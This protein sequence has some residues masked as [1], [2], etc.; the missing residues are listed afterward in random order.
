[1][2]L[3]IQ[4]GHNQQN[5]GNWTH[6]GWRK[7]FRF[8]SQLILRV[9]L[10]F[11]V[12]HRRAWG[13]SENRWQLGEAR[14]ERGEGVATQEVIVNYAACSSRLQMKGRKK[15]KYLETCVPMVSAAAAPRHVQLKIPSKV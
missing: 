11:I 3:Y 5:T 15:K 8:L 6:Y 13:A 4:T 9:T 2:Y 7:N 12:K 14:Q 10:Q 1:M